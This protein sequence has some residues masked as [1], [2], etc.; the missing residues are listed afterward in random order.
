MK[1]NSKHMKQYTLFLF[2]MVASYQAFA[3]Q[4]YNKLMTLIRQNMST[5]HHCPHD[6][7]ECGA[8]IILSKY[9]VYGDRAEILELSDAASQLFEALTEEEKAK[10][11]KILLATPGSF[12]MKLYCSNECCSKRYIVTEQ[13]SEEDLDQK[14]HEVTFTTN[15]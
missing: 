12:A 7:T 8:K 2:L 9:D 1:G 4:D 13:P 6:L 11:P 14:S 5:K 3:S 10:L 15:P